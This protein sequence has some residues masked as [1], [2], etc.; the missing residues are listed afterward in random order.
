MVCSAVT[1]SEDTHCSTKYTG[2]ALCLYKA[3][4]GDTAKIE[5]RFKKLTRK[6][7]LDF[8]LYPNKALRAKI[9]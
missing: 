1:A 2:S 7:K 6:L 3:D 5:I 4:L 8:C 9:H